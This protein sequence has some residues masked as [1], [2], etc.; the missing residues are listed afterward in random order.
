MS[1]QPNYSVSLR[2][3]HTHPRPGKLLL[4][5]P[6]SPDVIVSAHVRSAASS[7]SHSSSKSRRGPAEAVVALRW[8]PSPTDCSNF[9]EVK[10]SG[11]GVTAR[12]AAW[13]AAS[14]VGA[15]ATAA[16]AG[17]TM[18]GVRL[19]RR[20][21]GLGCALVGTAAGG[22]TL[23]SSSRDIATMPVVA[24]AVVRYGR[25]TLG[26]EKRP[27][28]EDPWSPKLVAVQRPG[29]LPPAARL[30]GGVAGGQLG[31]GQ[32]IL[33]R[34][35]QEGISAA[36]AFRSAPP[37][38][39]AAFNAILEVRNTPHA[40]SVW[41]NWPLIKAHPPCCCLPTLLARAVDSRR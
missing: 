15:F 28:A 17:D 31:D 34:A 40:L 30:V 33:A 5:P 11:S 14:G 25:F 10:A 13:H 23:R 16:T 27:V 22:A 9:A 35:R 29:G 12:G 37:G 19:S 8:Q 7:R 24:W 20:N 4:T 39:A 3:C 32:S 2:H 6:G 18:L 41:P 1:P 21:V 38:K 26:L 36:V